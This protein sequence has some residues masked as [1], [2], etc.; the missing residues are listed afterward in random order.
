[1]NIQKLFYLKMKFLYIYLIIS[2]IY[3]DNNHN[4]YFYILILSGI[5]NQH[6]NFP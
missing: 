4:N 6:F 2:A 5:N 1:M 3:F